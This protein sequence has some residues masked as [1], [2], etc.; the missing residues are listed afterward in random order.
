MITSVVVSSPH[1]FVRLRTSI[2]F[3]VSLSNRI[4]EHFIFLFVLIF[5]KKWILSRCPHILLRLRC[6]IQSWSLDFWLVLPNSILHV[7]FSFPELVIL[8]S[9][10]LLIWP[11]TLLLGPGST[12]RGGRNPRPDV[13]H[14]P[15][16]AQELCKFLCQSVHEKCHLFQLSRDITAAI[17][18]VVQPGRQVLFELIIQLPRSA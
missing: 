2:E 12:G 15:G 7:L 14:F 3:Y 9:T 16:I 6:Y 11:Y 1:A 13:V 4:V 18:F 8:M 5:Q 17:R 10:F